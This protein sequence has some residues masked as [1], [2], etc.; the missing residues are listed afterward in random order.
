[1]EDYNVRHF[2]A[3]GDGKADDSLAI[4]KSIDECFVAGGGRVFVPAGYVFLSGPFDLKSNIELH[5]E[6]GVKII[7]NPDESVYTESA[8]KQ[9][10]SE[11]TIWIGGKDAN[12]VAIT[13]GGIIDGQGIA[14]MDGEDP[15]AFKLK[16]VTDFDPRPHLLTL[17]GCSNITI[18]DIT[19]RNA[20]Y[21]CI[22]LAG[23]RDVIVNG[24]WIMNSLKIRNGDGIDPDHCRN[25]KISD[26]HIESGDDCICLKNRR[27]YS[28]YGPCENI[29]VSNCTLIST[30]CAIK[31]GS[32]NVD[33]IR[34]V[35]FDSCVISS[36]N[37]GIGIQ[38]RDEGSVENVIFSNMIIES[39]LFDDIWWGKSE[40]IYVTAFNRNPD[41][42]KRFPQNGVQKD[43]GKVKNIRFQNILCE[44]ENGVYISGSQANRPEDILLENI[45]LEINKW[46]KHR[47]GFM[48]ADR[49][50]CKVLLSIRLPDFI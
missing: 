11:G 20:A 2:G 17:V 43:V 7:A 21:W 39:R 47:G 25:V 8:F 6:R 36:S 28:E 1:M 22:H 49:V 42:V 16:P 37:R 19:F 24:I 3:V 5:V 46:T 4:Q 13:G 15:A 26:C 10:R 32:E 18:R 27:E 31:L 29:T 40:P 38:N 9:N 50:I 14:F 23:C 30:S 41:A 44:S 34:N 45:S 33:A 12:N 35:I 48:I